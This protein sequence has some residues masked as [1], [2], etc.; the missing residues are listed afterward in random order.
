MEKLLRLV[1]LLVCFPLCSVA[2]GLEETHTYGTK[3]SDEPLSFSDWNYVTHGVL[4]GGAASQVAGSEYSNYRAAEAKK[5]AREDCKAKEASRN[6]A[7][8]VTRNDCVD[9]NSYGA[10]YEKSQCPNVVQNTVESSIK[11]ATVTQ[12]STPRDTCRQEIDDRLKTSISRCES[13]YTKNTPPMN[14]DSIK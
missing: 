9:R 5:K 14:C 2:F 10:D 7:A 8:L 1:V 12:V 11:G 4:P 6:H 13:D 3:T